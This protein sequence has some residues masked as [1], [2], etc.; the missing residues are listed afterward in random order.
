MDSNMA[1]HCN[2]VNTDGCY[3]LD[4]RINGFATKCHKMVSHC[5][6]GNWE[7]C[8]LQ[9]DITSKKQ[10]QIYICF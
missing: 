6:K 1:L 5:V 2:C 7:K 10:S 8:S 3:V 4:E 9:N